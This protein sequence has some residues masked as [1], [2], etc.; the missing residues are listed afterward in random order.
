[1]RPL[2]YGAMSLA[3]AENMTAE[4]FDSYIADVGGARVP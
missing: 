1:M 4:Q 3:Q 2:R